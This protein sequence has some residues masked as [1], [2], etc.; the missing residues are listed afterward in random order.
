VKTF[1]TVSLAAS[2][3]LIA[4]NNGYSKGYNDAINDTAIQVGNIQYAIKELNLRVDKR[5]EQL[6]DEI[7]KNVDSRVDADNDGVLSACEIHSVECIDK[8]VRKNSKGG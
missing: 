3:Y 1:A 4:D 7:T 8:V 5:V 6:R 2:L